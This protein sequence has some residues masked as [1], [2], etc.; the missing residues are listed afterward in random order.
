MVPCYGAL[1]LFSGWGFIN[2]ANVRMGVAEVRL[3]RNILSEAFVPQLRR[4]SRSADTAAA[5]RGSV[6]SPGR[7]EIATAESSRAG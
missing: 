1:V 5:R 4:R 7:E 6:A 3:P 2:H